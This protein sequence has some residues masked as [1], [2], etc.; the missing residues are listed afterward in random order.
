MPV[1]KYYVQA[2]RTAKEKKLLKEGVTLPPPK[3]E[4]RWYFSCYYV[5]Y[6]TGQTVRKVKRGF[7]KQKEA[8]AAEHEFA[9]SQNTAS[10]GSCNM[11]FSE[12]ITNFM[13]YAGANYKPTTYNH[14]YVAIKHHILPC[15]KDRLVKSISKNDIQRWMKEINKATSMKTGKPYRTET[16]KGYYI[17]FSLIFEYAIEYHGLTVNPVKLCKQFR[18]DSCEKGRAKYYTPEEYKQF[19]SGIKDFK[20][21][22]LFNILYYGALRMGELLALRWE[23]VDFKKSTIYIGW[24]LTDRKCP[25]R[26]KSGKNYLLVSPKTEASEDY[27]PMPKSSMELLKKLKEQQAK[28]YYGFNDGWFVFGKSDPLT[29]GAVRY[30]QGVIEKRANVKHIRLHDFRHSL[31]TNLVNNNVPLPVVQRRLRHRNLSTTVDIYTH[32]SEEASQ[33]LLDMMEKKLI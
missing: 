8:I 26:E 15:F 33:L 16:K 25:Q 22:V 17:I 27:I 18:K 31:A 3:M 1:Y 28:K 23:Y 29:P 11:K 24:N 32:T 19:M 4:E 13:E 7:L 30:Q 14:C 2:K 12:L 10:I 21:Y 6:F 9:V 20:Y 5:D